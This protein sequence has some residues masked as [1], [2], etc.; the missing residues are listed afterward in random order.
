MKQTIFKTWGMYSTK[1]QEEIIQDTKEYLK[2][3]YPDKEYTEAEIEERAWEEVD[4]DFNTELTN[5]NKRLD[6]RILVIA[7]IGLWNGR[8]TGYKILGNNLNE[9][10]SCNISC[11]ERHVYYDRYNVYAEGKHHDDKNFVEFREIKE[12][13]DVSNLLKKLYYQKP[14]S[15]AE[16]RKYTKSLRPYIK[17]IY[18]V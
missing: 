6:G 16:I 7:D 11:D 18:G 13:K 10:V 2:E 5:L 9:V 12:D 15:R 14:V 8:K 1:E 4:F 3:W 17:E